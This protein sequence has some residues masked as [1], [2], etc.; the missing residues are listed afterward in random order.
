MTLEIEPAN[1]GQVSVYA[2]YYAVGRRPLLP[3]AVGLYNQ[4]SFEGNRQ[5]EGEAAI[6]FVATWPVLPLPSD[7]TLCQVQFDRDAELTYEISLSNFEF[8]DFLID[9]VSLSKRDQEPDFSRA[10]YK[11][12]MKRED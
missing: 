4:K 2:P 6:P 8:I 9:V 3:F 7:L 1:P 5:I 11:K 10:F 12:L